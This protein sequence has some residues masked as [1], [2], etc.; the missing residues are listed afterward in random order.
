MPRAFSCFVSFNKGRYLYLSSCL[1]LI[2]KRQNERKAVGCS[3]PRKTKHRK[4]YS[5]HFQKRYDRRRLAF[6][7]SE[8]RGAGARR[9][10]LLPACPACFLFYA[11]ASITAWEALFKLQGFA[12]KRV[13]APGPGRRARRAHCGPACWTARA[14]WSPAPRRRT[15]KSGHA[16]HAQHA[17]VYIAS[18][19]HQ[20]ALPIPD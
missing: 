1:G 20:S 10:C 14:G 2:Q 6:Q 9:R 3:F 13:K 19:H 17:V 8:G 11:A 12:R 16:L 7:A 4:A 5:I 15:C 18:L